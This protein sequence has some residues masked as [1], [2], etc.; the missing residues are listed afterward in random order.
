MQINGKI[1]SSFEI[2]IYFFKIIEGNPKL[3][4][5]QVK[6]LDE[7]NQFIK[8]AKLKDVLPFLS[9]YPVTFK[10]LKSND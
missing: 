5:E 2:T 4:I 3:V 8:F 1:V 7:N 6:V 10:P 9:K